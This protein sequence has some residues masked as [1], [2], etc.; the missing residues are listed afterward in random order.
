MDVI[1]AIHRIADL[2]DDADRSG[3]LKDFFQSVGEILQIVGYLPE[4]S[5]VEYESGFDY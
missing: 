5:D 4:P 1:D 3:D 2:W